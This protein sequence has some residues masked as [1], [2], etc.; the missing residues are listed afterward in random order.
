MMTIAALARPRWLTGAM[1]VGMLG[2]YAWLAWA[3]LGS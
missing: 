3:T 2:F 1:L